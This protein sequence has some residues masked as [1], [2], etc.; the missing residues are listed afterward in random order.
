MVKMLKDPSKFIMDIG[1]RLA[2]RERFNIQLDH[3][4]LK[5]GFVKLEEEESLVPCVHP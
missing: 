1:F 4:I 2:A 5:E 3:D